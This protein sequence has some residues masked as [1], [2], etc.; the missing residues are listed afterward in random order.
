VAEGRP[1]LALTQRPGAALQRQAGDV[2]ALRAESDEELVELIH[3][4]IAA[5]GGRITFAEFMELAL[6]EPQHGYYLGTTVRSA[7]QGDFLTAA[8]LHPVFGQVLAGQLAEMWLALGRP[9]PFVLREY[10]AGPG[11]LGL[12]V[13]ESLRADGSGLLEH[14]AYEPIELNPHHRL[15]ITERFEA[16][17]LSD[18]LAMAATAGRAGG[19]ARAG[20]G[21]S[22]GPITGVVLAN[23]FIDALPVHR[24]EGDR[25]RGLRELYVTWRDGWFAEESGDPSTP[26]LPAYFERLGIAL[27][28][29]QRAEV[30]LALEGW[31]DDV[32]AV[33]ARGY[34]LVIDYGH[35][36]DRLYSAGRGGGT[37]RAYH[38]HTAHD[39]AFRFVGR[40][41]LTAHVDLTALEARAS[42]RSLVPLAR[43]TQARFLVDAGLEA[44]LE[45]ERARADVDPAA[46]VALRAAI[47]RLLD[48]RALGGFHVVL[49]GRDVPA[50]RLPSGFRDA[51]GAWSG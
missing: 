30:D 23:E 1:A 36:A 34:V 32:A 2:D 51:E 27:A 28:P 31:L 49:L 35:P 46:Y 25:D 13:L 24:V 48:P 6:Y 39:D 50:D 47:P 3:D 17:G 10:G 41:D 37:L 21:P 22:R 29:G 5:A 33:L 12:A 8:E 16:A 14:L 9:S 42:E 44:I 40:Q 19:T 11:T 38:G 43:T 45:K 15:T 20:N 7:R 4:R 18:R 26:R